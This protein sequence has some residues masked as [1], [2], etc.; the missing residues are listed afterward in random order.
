MTAEVECTPPEGAALQ[1]PPRPY[2]GLRPFDPPEWPVFFGRER[3]VDELLDRLVAQRLV[4][5][6][7]DSGC[8]KSSLVRAGLFAQLEQ[9]RAGP[10][11]K[12]VIALPRREPLWNVAEALAQLG[13]ARPG[14]DDAV[15]PWRRALNFGAEAPAALA[16]LYAPTLAARGPGCLLIDQ[17]EEL[18]QHAQREGPAEAQLLTEMLVAWHAQPPA[19]LYLIT[20]MRSEYLGACARFG[21]FAETVNAAQYLLPRMEHADLLRAIR[22]PARLYNGEV[23]RELAERLIADAGG[24]QD[25]LPLMQHT[26][27]RL[28]ARHARRDGP[29]WRLD[30]NHFPAEGGCAGLLSAHADEVAQSVAGALGDARHERLVED[31]FR[32]LTE[33]NSEGQAIRRPMKLSEL[34]RVLDCDMAVLQKAVDAF[35]ADGVN[36]LTPPAARPLQPQTLIDV[37]HE[38]LIRCWRSLSEARDGW[39]VREFRNGLV[40]R[41]LLVQADSFENDATNVLAATT[42]EERQQWI[43]RRNAAWAERYGGGWDRVQKLLAASQSAK[44]ADAQQRHEA[45]AVKRRGAWMRWGLIGLTAAVVVSLWVVIS[46]RAELLESRVQ[47]ANAEAARQRSDWYQGQLE[48]ERERSA[49]LEAALRAQRT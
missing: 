39:L 17:F 22:E 42:T 25:Q 2:P 48:S 27:M 29:P 47:F 16:A 49:S 3:T 13:G 9:G 24:G 46:L 45:E 43:K 4:F 34:A 44:Q 7:G 40:W 33:I 23:S 1:L 38:A 19:G 15:M 14:D 30:T 8:G 31:L 36:F 11:W 26:L 5:V 6:H 41:A 21:R 12:T 20:T 35:R 37:G 10:G 18:F 32:A 28:H